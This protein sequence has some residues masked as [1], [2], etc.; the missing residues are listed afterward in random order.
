LTTAL[1]LGI[2]VVV[3]ETT[4]L[5]LLVPVASGFVFFF[6][7]QMWISLN[8]VGQ[9]RMLAVILIAAFGLIFYKRYR[10]QK[11]LVKENS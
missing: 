8:T 6:V 4:F 1:A 11:A 7:Y 9:G 3:R 2:I 10:L 5:R